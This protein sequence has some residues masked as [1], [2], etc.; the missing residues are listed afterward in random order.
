MV[1]N[2]GQAGCA[3]VRVTDPARTATEQFLLSGAAS[4]AVNQL[5]F[6]TLRGRK[7]YVDSTYF[8]AS[9]EKFVLG[10]LRASLLLG[11][12]ELVPEYEM[13]DVI[14]EVR[15]G[16][17]G[18]DRYDFLLGLPSV[19]ISADPNDGDGDIS[20]PF[21]TP[22][23]ALLKNI[24]QLGIASVAYVAYWRDSG[25]VVAKSGPFVGRSRREDW[26]FLG[27]GPRTVGDIA[28]AAKD[29]EE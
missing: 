24:K 7:V 4:K 14:L 3:T 18:I 21:V 29:Q 9:E 10:E 6:E 11:G 20:I 25:E 19:L 2:L 15:S 17:V 13:A 26:W 28:P 1:T 16:G 22:E 12:I 23:L 8:A 27:W 5:T